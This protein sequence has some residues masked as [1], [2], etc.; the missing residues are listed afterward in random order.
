MLFRS[1]DCIDCVDRLLTLEGLEIIYRK[2]RRLR[3]S[4]KDRKPCEVQPSKAEKPC[5]TQSK[6]KKPCDAQSEN[7]QKP[8]EEESPNE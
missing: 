8:C 2:N 1:V 6:D 4:S 7:E 3:H 5:D